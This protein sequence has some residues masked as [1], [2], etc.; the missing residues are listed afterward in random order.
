MNR[1]SLAVLFMAALAGCTATTPKPIPTPPPAIPAPPPANRMTPLATAPRTIAE[2]KIRVGMVS[3]Q[4]T[5]TFPRTTDGYLIVSGAGPSMLKRGFTITSPVSDTTK[6]YAV[7]A[8]AISDERSAQ[9]FVEKLKTATGQRVDS[10]FDPAGGLYKILVGDFADSPTAQPLREQLQQQGYGT[11]MQIVRRPTDQEFE[12]VLKLLDD[13]G[14]S[15]SIAG[16]S[17]LVLPPTAETVTIAV[18]PYRG[19]ARVFVNPRGLLNIINELSLEDYLRGVVPAEMGSRIY[20]ELEALKAQALAA[21]TYAVRNLGQYG[22]EGFDICPG[23]ACQAYNGFSGEEALTDQ[24]VKETAG[25]VITYE[26]K[27]IDA[28][29]T[30]TCGGHTSDVNTMFPG[31]QEPYL[32]AASCV[33]L[34]MTELAGRADSG[35]LSEPQMSARVFAALAGLT[36]EGASWTARDVEAAVT[37]AGKRIGMPPSAIAPPASSRRGDV[38][39]YLARA[40]SLDAAAKTLLLPEDRKYFFP[41]SGDSELTPYLAASFLIKYGVIPTQG[42]DRVDLNAAM[43]RE[44]L[45]AL[46][47][48]WMRKFQALN[49]ATGKIVAIN[50]RTLIL[51]ADGKRA[52]FALPDSIPV[53][54]KLGERYQEYRSVPV[55]LGD[56]AFVQLDGQKRV[57]AVVVQANFDGA[58]FDRTSSFSNWTRSYRADELVLS[59]NKRNPIKQLLGIRPTVIDA[60]NRVAEMEVTAEGGRV[61]TLKGLPVRWSLNI[62]DNV[63]VYTKSVDA[64]GMDRYTF[65]GKGW[66][67]GIGM[68]QVGAYGMAFRGWTAEQI[69]KRYYTGVEIVPMAQA[70][71]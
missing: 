53:F 5:V 45:Y 48:S 56:R 15:Y 30:A 9:A 39:M 52:S 13:E 58:A 11:N 1:I 65:F 63:F 7:Q 12:H 69:I 38:L 6:R 22:S 49:E 64:D 33:E 27:M 32:K 70:A 43:P 19:G 2:P 36:M 47:N 17:I 23:P 25:M 54:R 46:L 29:Y 67:H 66:G 42:I 51:K 24:A 59:I 8:G 10:V 34:E 28:L 44:E 26:G 60:S 37:A 57:A 61:F 41:Q 62:P 35:I 50:G 21:R 16:D 31:R 3:D 40:A 20:D 18:K 55:M 71:R 14:D 68:C 4:T